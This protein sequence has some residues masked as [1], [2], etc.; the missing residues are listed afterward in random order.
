MNRIAACR[1]IR[2]SLCPTSANK[3]LGPRLRLLRGR[4]AQPQLR[5]LATGAL[6]RLRRRRHAPDPILPFGTESTGHAWLHSRC[7]PTWHA[8]RKAEAIAALAAMGI[9][10]PTEFPSSGSNLE[11]ENWPSGGCRLITFI[12]EVSPVYNF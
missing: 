6:S 3:T 5:A 10:E 11:S 7:W 12:H 4:M 9:A 1:H 2:R 8:G